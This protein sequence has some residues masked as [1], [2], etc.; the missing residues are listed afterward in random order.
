MWDSNYQAPIVRV[1]GQVHEEEEGLGFAEVVKE[2]AREAGFSKFRVFV[3]QNGVESEVEA[4][5]A[6]D[7][8]REG[9]EVNIKPYEKAA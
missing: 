2:H 3:T 1:C 7:V 8:L 5:D 9:M 6:P 4:D